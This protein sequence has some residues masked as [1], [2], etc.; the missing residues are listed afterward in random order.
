MPGQVRLRRVGAMLGVG[1]LQHA[2]IHHWAQVTFY[3]VPGTHGEQLC[4]HFCVH[5]APRAQT[6]DD[7]PKSFGARATAERRKLVLQFD[8]K[9]VA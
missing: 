4:E 8:W 3:K 6:Q 7:G 9:I 2:C 1:K 5:P